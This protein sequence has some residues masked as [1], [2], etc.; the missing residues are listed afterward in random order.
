VTGVVP[1]TESQM[2]DLPECLTGG[3]E[4][5]PAASPAAGAVFAEAPWHRGPEPAVITVSEARQSVWSAAQLAEQ[6][7]ALA[8]M[9]RAQGLQPG[10]LVAV[11]ERPGIQL[12]LM[13]HALAQC[14]AALLPIR[15]AADDP[16]GD[17]LLAG[18]GAEWVWRAAG[19]DGLTGGRLVRLALRSARVM[20]GTVPGSARW[21][22]PLALVVETSGSS[23]APRAAMLTQGNVL[24]AAALSN[25]HLDLR[26]GDRWL[27]CL[28]LR[29]IGG[30]SILYRCALAGAAVVLQN[31]FDAGAVA[32]A[33]VSRAVTHLSLVP[34]ML[35]RLLALGHPPPVTL[36]VVLVGGQSLSPPLARQAIAAGWPLHVTYG[37][38]ETAAQIATSQRLVQAPAPGVI[39]QPLAGIELDCPACADGSGRL[40]VRG[41]VVMAGYAN[42][43]R[44]PGV[45]LTDG[46]F[47]TSDLGCRGPDG[48]LQILGRADEVLVTGGVNVHPGRVE[49]IL[50]EAPGVSEA[51]VVGVADPVWGQRL[52]ALYRGE[53]TPA[54]LDAWCRVRLPGAERPRLFLPLPELP[55]LASGKLDR[56]GLRALAQAADG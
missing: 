5:V 2:R 33:I 46:W 37:M 27:C 6:S 24:A 34:P 9:L 47:T 50:A 32:A 31:G 17:A 56:C 14:D 21:S 11:P 39:G 42:S 19:T 55:V 44:I 26:A 3:P 16:A 29:H 40:R 13:L 36:R 15:A 1:M 45:G 41:P 20:P 53:A 12:I 10:H 30:L 7:A 22:S 51:A 54:A 4:A 23:G 18:T 38:T 25:R 48:A 43:E 49:A 52:V 28:P 35:A 8:V